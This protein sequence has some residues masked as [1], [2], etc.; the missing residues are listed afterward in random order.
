MSTSRR[1]FIRSSMGVCLAAGAGISAAAPTL[2]AR[3]A[4]RSRPRSLLIL[5]GTAFIGPHIIDAARAAGYEVTIF[6]RGVTEVRTQRPIDGVEKIVGDRDPDKG[7]GLKN[8]EARIKEKGGWDAVIDTSGY[9]PRMVKASA[10]LLAPVVGQHIFISS[11]SV[12]A[13]HTQPDMDE[14]APV[15]TIDDPTVEEMG[16]GY[17]NYGPLKALCEQAVEAALPGRACNVRPG[18]IVGP[19]DPTDRFTYWPVRFDKGGEVL[20][21]GTPDDPVQFIDVRDL[22]RW[23]VHLVEKRTMG[24]FNATG[25]V[26]GCTVGNFVKACQA[27]ASSPSTPVYVDADF[28]ENQ[29]LGGGVVTI[30]I[31]NRGDAAGFH[32]RSIARAVAAGFT[33]RPVEQ[34]VKDTLA[35]WPGEVE[36]RVRVTRDILASAEEENAKLRAEGKEEKPLPRMADPEKLRAGLDPER[37]AAI[38]TAYR[39]RAASAPEGAERGSDTRNDQR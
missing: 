9:Y 25:P 34:T 7:D 23:L 20:V 4:Q 39:E 36:R 26:G 6:N 21:P 13:D 8:L 18:F 2:A 38:L 3:A 15:G 5:G 10:E 28:L 29:G 30:L 14:S 12:Y 33:S 27:A 24:V 1:D 16:P 32:R 37:E 11:I 17:A 31:P 22:A 19:G 35:W